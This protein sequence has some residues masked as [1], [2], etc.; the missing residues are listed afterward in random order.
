MADMDT[1]APALPVQE[2]RPPIK[3]DRT[4]A[5]GTVHGDRT[6]RDPHYRVHYWQGDLPFDA[7]GNLIPDDGRIEP[8]EGVVEGI[9][10]MFEP[11]YNQH[12]RDLV[13]KKIARLLR[14]RQ[15]AAEEA[16][17]AEAEPVEDLIADVNLEQMLQSEPGMYPF[18]MVAEAC[19]QRFF[20]KH[21]TMRSVVE[22][23]VLEEKIVP[24]QLVHKAWLRMLDKAA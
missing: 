2:K 22:D 14:G 18:W 24:E 6:P 21:A 17:G 15:E 8:Y 10:V 16:L 3:L 12:R 20:K 11:L 7:A 23:L 13:E 9:K 5:F 1:T 19:K 4:R